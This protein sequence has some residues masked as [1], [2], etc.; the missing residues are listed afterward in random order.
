MF[1]NESNSSAVVF[2]SLVCRHRN[3]TGGIGGCVSISSSTSSLSL[4]FLLPQST[5][6]TCSRCHRRLAVQRNKV[7]KSSSFAGAVHPSGCDS[8]LLA[9]RAS[10]LFPSGVKDFS[11]RGIECK[12]NHAVCYF[13]AHGLNHLTLGSANSAGIYP[14]SHGDLLMAFGPALRILQAILSGFL[15]TRQL[16]VSNTGPFSL[17]PGT[18]LS[19]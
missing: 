10:H 4:A 19:P 3:V 13:I 6:A 18:A 9:L 7:I 17:P 14:D 8:T 1:I 15:L 12:A 16:P 5:E 2:L 11:R